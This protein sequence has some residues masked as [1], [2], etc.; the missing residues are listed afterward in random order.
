M[1]NFEE[2]FETWKE[3]E[4]IQLVWESPFVFSWGSLGMMAMKRH[5]L[6]KTIV[7]SYKGVIVCSEYVCV[8]VC[9]VKCEQCY[10]DN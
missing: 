2:E 1:K 5:F 4:V 6:Q 9:V 7:G 10:L 8:C 3:Y